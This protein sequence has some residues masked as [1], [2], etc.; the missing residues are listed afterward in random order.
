MKLTTIHCMTLSKNDLKKKTGNKRTLSVKKTC[1]VNG[2]LDV[3]WQN[4][5]A[6]FKGF[7]QWK[8]RPTLATQVAGGQPELESQTQPP[9][10]KNKQKHILQTYMSK[11]YKNIYSLNKIVRKRIQ[12]NRFV[13]GRN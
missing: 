11:Y 9:E 2:E 12:H 7:R 4:S 10:F 5:N 3:V 1:D 13:K 8:T 6:G